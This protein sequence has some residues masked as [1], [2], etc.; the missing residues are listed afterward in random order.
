MVNISALSGHGPP[1]L[2]AKTSKLF[3]FSAINPSIPGLRVWPAACSRSKRRFGWRIAGGKAE[4]R[5]TAGL[6]M[7]SGQDNGT[8]FPAGPITALVQ[9]NDLKVNQRLAFFIVIS[10]F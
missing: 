8:A 6:P 5:G 4:T 3:I 7:R 1:D 10:V 9:S 2:P